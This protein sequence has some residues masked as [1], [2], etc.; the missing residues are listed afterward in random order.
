MPISSARMQ[1][2]CPRFPS[3]SVLVAVCVGRSYRQLPIR[4]A[5]FGVL[6]R[7]ELSHALSGLTRVRSFRQDDAHIFCTQDQLRAEIRDCLDMLKKVYSILGRCG[8][9]SPS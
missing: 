3:L 7:N 6:H 8:A 5:D 2:T 4:L 1:F 9:Y